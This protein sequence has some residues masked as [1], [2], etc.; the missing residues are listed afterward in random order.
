MRQLNLVRAGVLAAVMAASAR[1]AVIR[2]TVVENFTG[3]PLARALVLLQPVSS[4]AGEVRTTRANSL[5]GFEFDKLA[6][7]AYIVKASR[8]GFMPLESGQKRWN[9]A[10]TP[11]VL[12]DADAGVFLNLRLIRF[13][14]IN[15]TLSDENDVGLPDHDV[16]AYRNSEPPELVAQATTDDRGAYRLHGLEP[17]TYLVRSA[18]K[19]YEDVSYLATF[20]KDAE[21]LDQAH[22]IDLTADQDA[23][24]INLRPVTGHLYSLSAA[25]EV[26]PPGVEVI[27][28]LASEMG[29]KT[30]KSASFRLAGLPAGDYEI[31]AEERVEE[32]TVRSAYQRVLLARDTSVTLLLSP[33]ATSVIVAGAPAGDSGQ[34]W[35]RRKD[36]AGTGPPMLAQTGR[37]AVGILPAGRWEILLQP[38]S[39][40][41]VSGFGAPGVNLQPVKRP[42]VWNEVLSRFNSSIRLALT[43]GPSA[44]RGIVK[45][46]GDGVSG[47]PVYLEVYDPETRKRLGDLRSARSDARGQYRFDGLAPGTY[48]VLSTFEYLH[49]DPQAMDLAQ[50][51]VVTLEA[52]SDLAMDLDLYVIQ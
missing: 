46:H 37:G 34:L 40:Y 42:D 16:V 14:A 8:I 35:A 2:G 21:K 32:K 6:A 27:L 18:G 24:N 45:S 36:V 20:F 11:V 39:G 48:R 12:A 9:S 47:A 50:A 19:Q 29:R 1:A 41:Y 22:T 38:P 30:F 23:D 28:T 17:G 7:G 26:V 10:G 44:I 31:Y 49:P 51:P 43:A 33:A 3:K 15:G 52:H 4:A 5:G 13:S 25:A